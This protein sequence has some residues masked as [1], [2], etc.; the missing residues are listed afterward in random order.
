MARRRH[1]HHYQNS[2]EGV[3]RQ[4]AGPVS[5]SGP[6]RPSRAHAQQ[7]ECCQSCRCCR[8]RPSAGA[9]PLTLHCHCHGQ[10]GNH[11][12]WDRAPRAGMGG[13]V[14]VR[15]HFSS[16]GLG[17]HPE[18][19][20]DLTPILQASPPTRGAAVCNSP[21]GQMWSQLASPTSL[22]S[23][24]QVGGPDPGQVTHPTRAPMKVQHFR[25]DISLVVL[26]RV[27]QDDNSE[28]P[29]APGGSPVS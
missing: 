19:L 8:D 17:H 2:L 3:P 29:G 26:V 11:R 6:G 13:G 9:P 7:A 28:G 10:A 15:R 18:R 14:G 5:P 1:P 20:P 12:G 4:R 23:P 16:R 25:G 27:V 24:S 22:H 21:R